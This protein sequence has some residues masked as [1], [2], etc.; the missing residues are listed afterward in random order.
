MIECD[1]F[2]IGGGPAGSISAAK[3]V[4]E[5]FDVVVV[6][7]SDFPRFVIGESLLPECNQ[8]LEDANM[9]QGVIDAGFQFKGGACFENEKEGDKL[10]IYDFS[11]NRGEKWGSSFQV[12]REEFDKILL[13][14][15][16]SKGATVHIGQEVVGYDPDKNIITVE[17]RDG[18]TITYHAKKVLD[19]SGYGRVLPKLLDLDTA[20]ELPTR[21]ATFCR[22]NNDVRPS[23]Y[24]EGYIY[25]YV[26]GDNDAWI[27]NIPFSDG[28][29]SVGIVCKEDY[30]QSFNMSEEAFFDH[31]IHSNKLSK[32]RYKNSEK[33][34]EVGTLNGYS[35]AVKTMVGE[36][37]LLTGN[38]SEFLDPVF[39]SGVTLA[40]E[41]GSTA[42][43]LVARELRGESIDY[44]KEYEEYMML[45]VNVFREFVD[46]WYD[47]RLQDI[48][49]YKDENPQIKKAIVSILSGYVWDKTNIFV[50]GPK[51]AIDST[52]QI[53]Q[54]AS[55]A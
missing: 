44:K 50:K 20:P 43:T 37:F 2:I 12:R 53:I 27:W 11:K 9:L 16:M 47:G 48:F 5:G 45:G 36:N 25:I 28:I 21:R 1:V 31:V 24:T 26:H 39:S 46:A 3:L 10:E 55:R 41:S 4:Q 52:L 29:T 51:Q 34:I 15:A 42:A 32:E 22:L 23:D 18:E 14:D 35:A 54:S 49:F 40:L 17:T 13:D 19:A 7:R 38:A 6:D 33:T 8:L 30:F